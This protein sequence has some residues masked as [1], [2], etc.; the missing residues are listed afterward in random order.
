[1]KTTLTINII[2]YIVHYRKEKLKIVNEK[3]GK[4]KSGKK[5]GQKKGKG[6]TP[7]EQLIA[8][9]NQKQKIPVIN[10]VMLENRAMTR[11]CLGYAA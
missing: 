6:G 9:I 10:E 2:Y 3:K 11:K 4:K 5:G 7:N 1:M 8:K